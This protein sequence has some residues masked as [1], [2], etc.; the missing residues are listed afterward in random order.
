VKKHCLGARVKLIDGAEHLWKITYQRDLFSAVGAVKGG[1][2]YT[3]YTM[4]C[5]LYST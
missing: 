1:T 4:Y 2:Y 5:I 3:L